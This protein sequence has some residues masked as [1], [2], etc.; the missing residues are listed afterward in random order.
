MAVLSLNH[1]KESEYISNR[2]IEL[3]KLLSEEFV[4]I[5]RLRTISHQKYGFITRELRSII[6]PKLLLIDNYSCYDYE[7]FHT[8]PRNRTVSLDVDRSLWNIDVTLVSCYE[9]TAC[10]IILFVC[11]QLL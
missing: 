6:W 7:E 5:E 8:L 9:L 10:I 1:H 11:D 2:I 4:D 3:K